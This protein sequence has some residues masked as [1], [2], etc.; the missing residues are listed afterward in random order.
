MEELNLKDL[1]EYYVG[2]IWY[3][4]LIIIISGSLSVI[5]TTFFKNPMY[6]SYTTLVL[7]GTGTDSSTDGITQS[8]VTLNQKLVS[9]YREI[10]KSRNVINQVIH[11]LNLSNTYDYI[12]NNITVTTEKD[13]ELIK[14][15]VSNPDA[16][17][18]KNIAD[19]IANVFSKEIV[20]IY[21][22]R[23]VALIDAGEIAQ[24]PYNINL[25]K[26]TII[27]VLVGFVIGCALIFVLYYFD[28]TV[29]SAE[30]IENKLHLPILGSV[31][32]INHLKE[33]K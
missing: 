16:I 13:T 32:D 33:E 7:A 1:F 3:I 30:E 9:T 8:E 4:I 21:N 6:R 17:T 12:A 15:S 14:I 20:K 24:K 22:I 28:T 19:E 2:K 31:P 27:A 23:N 26:E 10:M 11:N 18:A 29:K 25:V 5:Y